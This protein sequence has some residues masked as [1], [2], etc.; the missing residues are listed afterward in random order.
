MDPRLRDIRIRICQVIRK[1][2]EHQATYQEI[3]D[4]IDMTDAGVMSLNDLMSGVTC[5]LKVVEGAVSEK[6]PPIHKSRN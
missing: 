5:R 3:L 6:L 1:V 4:L 2:P